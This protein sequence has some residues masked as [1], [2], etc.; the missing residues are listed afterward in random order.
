MGICGNKGVARAKVRAAN[1]KPSVL[2]NDLLKHFNNNRDEALSVYAKTQTSNFETLYNSATAQ[3]DVN[4]EPLIVDVIKI[5]G[6]NYDLKAEPKVEEESTIE[7]TAS[8]SVRQTDVNEEL[9]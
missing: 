9:S 6:D 7:S 8:F 3:K 2:Y 1:G 4:G 5:I